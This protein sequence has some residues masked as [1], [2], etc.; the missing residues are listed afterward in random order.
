MYFVFTTRIYRKVPR[1]SSPPLSAPNPKKWLMF[2]RLYLLNH[3]CFCVSFFIIMYRYHL[4]AEMLSTF[5]TFKVK[6]VCTFK[7]EPF[8]IVGGGGGGLICGT[9][10]Y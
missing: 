9:L 7:H 2:K 8:F 6:E 1:I 3:E 4:V 10:W 5:E